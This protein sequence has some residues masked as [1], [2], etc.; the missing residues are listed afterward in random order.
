[1]YT[2][3]DVCVCISIAIDIDT[4]D[5]C[6]NVIATNIDVA[7]GIEV[8][9]GAARRGAGDW[10]KPAEGSGNGGRGLPAEGRRHG[11]GRAR[12]SQSG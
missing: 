9:M 10:G 3:V 2:Y 7:I 8:Y 11:K 1:M 4:D 12:T 6:E 5:V